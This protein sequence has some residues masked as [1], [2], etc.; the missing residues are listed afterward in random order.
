MKLN[1]VSLKNYRLI[2]EARVNLHTEGGTTVFVGPNNSGK[3]SVAEALRM[4]LNA[5]QKGF[6]F[7]DF[8][9]G[10]HPTFAAFEMAVLAGGN[11]PPL[12]LIRMELTFSYSD[13]AEDLSV[14]EELL[15]D[16]DDTKAEVVLRIDYCSRS[17]EQT[18]Q[19]FKA[20]RIMRPEQPLTAMLKETLER[21]YELRHYKVSTDGNDSEMLAPSA[22]NAL[23]KRLVKVDFLPAQRH[24]E[25]Q[26][27]SS[28]ATKLSRLLHVHYERRF[29]TS[30]PENYAAVEAVVSAQA[31]ELTAKYGEAFK[32]VT[33]ALKLFGYPETPEILVQA[34]LSAGGIFKDSTKIYY[35]ASIDPAGDIEGEEAKT[36]QLP[37]RFN[38]LGFKNLIYMVLQLKAFRDAL[39]GEDGF[40]PR[41]HLIVV[42]EPEAHLH[43]QMQTVFLRKAQSFLSHAGEEGTQL[44][45]TTH[46]SHITAA[47]GLSAVRYFRKKGGSA[48]VKDLMAFKGEETAKGQGEAFEFVA[49]Y[50][51]LTRCDLF[52]ADKAILIEGSVERLLLPRM[53]EA[54]S[55]EGVDLTPSYL[56]IVEVGGAYAHI[57]KD[58]LEFLGIPTLII[59][60]LDSIKVKRVKCRVD[61]G[62]TTSNATLTKWLPGKV[63]LAD[64]RAATP[65]QLTD[66]VIR[67]AFQVSET[68][69]GLCGRSFEEAFC[70]AN[71]EWLYANKGKLLG[72]GDLF[73]H[74]DAAALIADAYNIEFP[75]ADFA[76]DLMLVAGWKT[77]K[78][79]KDGLA[80][81]AGVQG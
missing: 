71:A 48:G 62:I 46:S 79:I 35:V 14:A 36:H 73:Q 18:A 15:M 65:E 42:E 57:F 34:E 47:A 78:Y 23:L 64:I 70:Y 28:Q 50:L 32:E 59:T 31:V 20:F 16:L 33:E 72:T 77:P 74:A 13:I 5:T 2:R 69:A 55:A 81:L 10:T 56:S 9:G 68:N 43:P 67:V 8:W 66:G 76:V 22:A 6:G 75:K 80:W 7:D 29:K 52:Y 3:T 37:E 63:P 26:E 58:F 40:R 39:I 1:V 61:E 27:A 12:P 49:K 41:V 38:G 19:D 21:Q 25:D 51:T 44:V 60:D 4:F 53:I 54:A 17:P 30:D 11:L 45:I 24:M